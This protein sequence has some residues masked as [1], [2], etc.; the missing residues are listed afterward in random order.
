MLLQGVLGKSG[1][2][3]LFLI[4]F[5]CFLKIFLTISSEYCVAN[6]SLS[7][8]I[9]TFLFRAS[10]LS[11]NEMY[12]MCRITWFC[13]YPLRVCVFESLS[14]N[15]FRLSRFLDIFLFH[16][17][18]LLWWLQVGDR[19]WSVNI[20]V[21]WLFW[22]RFWGLGCLQIQIFHLYTKWDLGLLGVTDFIGEFDCGVDLVDVRHKLFKVFSCSG[23]Y[24]D[25]LQISSKYG[26][27][28]VL[29]LLIVLPIYP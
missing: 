23:P 1:S 5:Q 11:L 16:L 15:W 2:T 18:L 28:L 29:G 3:V 8:L 6:M 22:C 7:G 26:L 4:N 12:L 20:V 10:F 24:N 17:W 9:L 13:L 25:R 27:V 19:M 21:Y 14:W